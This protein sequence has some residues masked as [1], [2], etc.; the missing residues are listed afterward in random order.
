MT[1]IILIGPAGTG[2]STQGN[3]LAERLGIPQLSLDKLRWAYYAEIG[4]DEGLARTI[5]ETQGFPAL[6][7]YWTRFSAH[8]VERI[9]ADHHNCVIDFGAGAGVY[10]DAKDFKRLQQA[11]APYPNVVL[12]MPSLDPD[13]S[14][15]ILTERQM[16]LAPAADL[17]VIGGI[18]EHQVKHHGYYDLAK[19]VIYTKG[20]TPEE[21]CDDLISR[22]NLR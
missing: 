12:I 16:S 8:S 13:E 18:I 3:L 1:E 10:E 15:Q 14:I 11:L 20:K 9:L 19:M 17:P 6:M 21:M 4:Y 22:L 7:E 2:K 5:R